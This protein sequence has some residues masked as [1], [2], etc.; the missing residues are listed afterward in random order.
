MRLLTHKLVL[1]AAAL[2]LAAAS[3]A[4]AQRASS[5]G[6]TKMLSIG[7]GFAGGASLLMDPADNWKV[8]PVFAWRGTVDASYPI[9]DVVG[10]WL[11]LGLDRR[12]GD[13]YWYNDKD[14]R[15][16]RMVNYFTLT[17]GINVKGLV[18]G[19]NLGFPMGGSRTYQNGS[20]AGE[21]TLELDADADGLSMLIEPRIW[22]AI[23]LLDEKIGWLGITIGA[24]YAL[25]DMTDDPG[26]LP[27]ET[28]GRTFSS[29]TAS[30]HLGFV[31]MFG[32]PGTAR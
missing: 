9:N 25:S 18:L 14:L 21:R 4:T 32:I 3:S 19:V 6:A 2:L 10:A 20:D 1:G 29:G 22:G 8:T 13:F 12:G 17:P 30:A 27:G 31:W 15:E 24:G 26:F 16:R 23:P 7:A 28:D 5:T 11:S